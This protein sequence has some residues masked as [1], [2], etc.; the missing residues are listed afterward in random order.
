MKKSFTSLHIL[1]VFVFLM[2]IS[3]NSFSQTTKTT[4]Q[5]GK[6]S[7]P[8]T[9]TGGM[10]P[11]ASNKATINDHVII[12]MNVN[13]LS[14]TINASSS[15]TFDTTASY[16][17]T[18]ADEVIVNGLFAV[19][20]NTTSPQK[21]YLE[22]GADFYGPGA[23]DFYEENGDMVEVVFIGNSNSVLKDIL[24]VTGTG[25]NGKFGGLR[26]E[27]SIIGAT[28]TLQKSLTINSGKTTGQTGN[29]HVVKGILDFDSCY[30]NAGDNTNKFIVD[31][32]GK[33]YMASINE[34]SGAWFETYTF[35]PNSLTKFYASLPYK[36]TKGWGASN[37]T[38]GSFTVSGAGVKSFS[39]DTATRTFNGKFYIEP[40]AVFNPY[41]SV[42]TFRDEYTVDGSFRSDSNVT[43]CVFE[44]KVVVNDK[45][46]WKTV[47]NDFLKF[48]N[49]F[50]VSE[51]SEFT[52]GYG[53]YIFQKNDQEIH[54]HDTI[55]DLQIHIINLL[56]ADTLTCKTAIG[57]G[58][59]INKYMFVYTGDQIKCH[60]NL[61]TLDNTVKYT[62]SDPKILANNYQ[63]LEISGT[64]SAELTGDITIK[65]Q[66]I[67]KNNGYLLL[68]D[69]S[70]TLDT[71]AVF[72][73]ANPSNMKMIV[74]NST[75]SFITKA[76]TAARFKKIYPIGTLTGG[77]L[78]APFEITND[79]NHPGGTKYI[80]VRTTKGYHPALE[81]TIAL[82]RYWTLGTDMTEKDN[83]GINFKFYYN[84]SEIS[85]NE[86]TYLT[87]YWAGDKPW[88]KPG[89]S[90]LNTV[91]NQIE[92]TDADL[93]SFDWTAGDSASLTS[94]V[95]ALQFNYETSTYFND[96]Y[97]SISTTTP[98]V[99]IYYTLNGNNP[100]NSDS[101]YTMPL[102]INTA[103]S[104]KAIGMKDGWKNTDIKSANYLFKVDSIAFSL[105]G[106]T[107]KGKQN[108]MLSTSTNDAEIRYTLD[109]TDPD[110]SSLLY[111]IPLVID[112]NLLIKAKGFKANYESSEI[113]EMEYYI[114]FDTVDK[115]KFSVA[116]GDYTTSISVQIT[117]DTI[118]T[119]IYYNFGDTIPNKEI[120]TLY[121]SALTLSDTCKINAIA[122]KEGL[123]ESP[124]SSIMYNICTSIPAL[125]NHD[126][127]SVYPIPTNGK[128]YI[129]LSKTISPDSEV[130]IDIFDL[131][132]KLMFTS[133]F[134]TGNII[135]LDLNKLEG[136]TYLM[137]IKTE[138]APDIIKL[139][140]IL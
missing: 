85:G 88:M 78:Y 80:S 90:A 8:N 135:E 20:G 139:V 123:I 71:A 23:V 95:N 4:K 29:L 122:Y 86:T 105:A 14:L 120:G 128:L 25:S 129:R 52:C 131:N 45:A 1:I 55:N 89:N 119:Q 137:H 96:L 92:V 66:F 56:N 97:L 46:L 42:L 38:F 17:F 108:L 121:T 94:T 50:Y 68:G 6:W 36:M 103:T 136:G 40:N 60:L 99:N 44:K 61:E 73:F 19:S 140:N 127:I 91:S 67:K 49:G 74:T 64:G 133:A 65:D 3:L 39:N 118:N 84:E 47:Y 101:L 37:I 93:I 48:E 104:L 116:G 7:D 63:I 54:L 30:V 35:H 22:V 51:L 26:V 69:Y 107:Y 79:L 41:N 111:Q 62:H 110:T 18:V 75:G 24:D 113:S 114:I 21:H 138:N 11:D 31:S 132:A 58:T 43:L 125:E 10:I 32:L 76:N 9:W 81:D 102:E 117:T 83:I 87:R 124:V 13:I 5:N 15:L 16:T 115:P 109:N 53:S 100:T 57:V 70:M 134:K 77:P 98:D 33:V 126:Q 28:V 34:F 130:D 106:G 59:L 72:D 27:K 82:Q 2:I 12:D 112:T